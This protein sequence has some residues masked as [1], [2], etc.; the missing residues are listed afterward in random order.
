MK[1]ELEEFLTKFG[2]FKVGV[3]NPE[4][5]FGMAKEGCHPRDVMKNCN[6]VIAFAFHTGLDYYT[7]LDY[8]QKRDVESRVLSIYCDWVS[9]QFANFLKDKGYN[10]VVSHGF[11]DEKEKIARLS[12]KLAAYETG[13]GV[14]GRPSILITPEYGPRV[15]LRVVLTDASIQPDEPLKSFNPC[16]ECDTCVRLCPINAI[17]KELP[18]PRG[19]NRSLCLQFIDKIREKTNRRIRYCGYCYNHC[20]VGKISKKTFRLSRWK[21]LLDLSEQEKKRLL[22]SLT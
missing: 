17:N 7:I 8:S 14:F 16:Q 1:D 9:Y 13:L 21:T 4:N 18:P 10:A 12:F 2:V 11:R 19:F 15:N 20:P 6:S 22:Q 3:A 5:G